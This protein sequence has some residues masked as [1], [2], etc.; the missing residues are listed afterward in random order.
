MILLQLLFC[1]AFLFLLYLSV[2][3]YVTMKQ[4]LFFLF[5]TSLIFAGCR[6]RTDP[7]T[8][9]SII[10]QKDWKVSLVRNSGVNIT[11]LYLGLNFT[12]SADST[13]TI[14][15]GVNVYGGRWEED[16]NARRFTLIINSPLFELGLISRDWDI[17]LITPK[18]LQ[19]RDNRFAPTQELWFNDWE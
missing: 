14:S 13:V 7:P 2:I 6:K 12:F 18:Q 17:Q 16:V 19:F 4:F 5:I 8:L 10:T 15:D 3:N 1:T 11:T 9:S